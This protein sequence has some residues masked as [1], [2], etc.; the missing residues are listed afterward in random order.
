VSSSS[1]VR[2]KKYW[3]D[4]VTIKQ[5]VQNIRALVS[6]NN[7]GLIRTL[8]QRYGEEHPLVNYAWWLVQHVG[9]LRLTI[10]ERLRKV[11]RKLEQSR[12]YKQTLEWARQYLDDVMR[13]VEAEQRL[14]RFLETLRVAPEQLE[15]EVLGKILD[16][17][18]GKYGNIKE[19]EPELQVPVKEAVKAWIKSF[20]GA[21]KWFALDLDSGVRHALAKHFPKTR[22][23]LYVVLK[24]V[25]YFILDYHGDIKKTY[26]VTVRTPYV[27]HADV[28]DANYDAYVTMAFRHALDKLEAR[29]VRA[30][31]IAEIQLAGRV[32]E[33]L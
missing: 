23:Q 1:H 32:K 13:L 30:S 4:I 12:V 19:I 16:W 18:Q 7:T 8:V 21:T 15:K 17:L 9:Q 28:L 27:V 31:Q 10:E 22:I 26:I 29:G 3:E 33:K 25:D 5:R 6:K 20:G 24:A 14:Q 2:R 11:E